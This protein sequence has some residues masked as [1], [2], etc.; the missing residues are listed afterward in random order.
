MELTY[1]ELKKLIKDK[2]DE[3]KVIII[4]VDFEYNN[5]YTLAKYL[6]GKDLVLN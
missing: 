3:E 1:G 5:Y 6:I 4:S 2:P